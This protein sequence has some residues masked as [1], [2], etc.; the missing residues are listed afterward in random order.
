MHFKLGPGTAAG[1]AGERG[2]GSRSSAA[3]VGGRGRTVALRT[4]PVS[5]RTRANLG[6]FRTPPNAGTPSK[7]RAL[8][9]LNARLNA[10]LSA[11]T[12][13]TYSD[14]QYTNDLTQALAE[15]RAAYYQAA[16]PP[17]SVLD[18]ALYVVRQ[19]SNALDGHGSILYVLKKQ[20]FF[21]IEICTG[22]KVENDGAAAIG[23]YTFGPC[24]GEKTTPP[25]GLPSLSPKAPTT[26]PPANAAR[27]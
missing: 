7:G 23:G 20:R 13:V 2:A 6:A 17:Q 14:R 12:A 11:G 10:S 16:A 8:D 4:S 26:M 25:A 3:G 27:T 1:A 19:G 18:R 24:T 5:S 21:G 9:A 22:W 15:A